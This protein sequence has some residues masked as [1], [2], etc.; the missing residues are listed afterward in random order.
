MEILSENILHDSTH[1]VVSESV[2]NNDNDL[3]TSSD[4]NFGFHNRLG[5]WCDRHSFM[6]IAYR[7]F[8]CISM[9]IRISEVIQLLK[10]AEATVLLDFDINDAITWADGFEFPDD[11]FNNDIA[12]ILFMDS[13]LPEFIRWNNQKSLILG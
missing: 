12:K 1:I 13:N 4:P 7:L 8:T 10:L 9:E 5:R 11:A 3:I 6:L 2:L